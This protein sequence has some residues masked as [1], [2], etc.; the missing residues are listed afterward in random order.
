MNVNNEKCALI[1]GVSGQDGAYLAAFLIE[2]GYRVIG[3]TRNIHENNENLVKL[4]IVSKIRLLKVNLLNYDDVYNCI[5]N[6]LPDEIYHLSGQSSVGLSFEEPL[7][8]W[9]SSAISTTNILESVRKISAEIKIFNAASGECFDH[10]S[11]TPVTE[12]TQFSPNSPYSSAKI[13]S[14]VQIKLY[15]NYYNL[16]CSNGYLFNHES[17]LRSDKFVTIKII[18]TIQ[19]IKAGK[20]NIL[21]LGNIN[22]KRDWG[23]APEYVQAMWLMLQK[24]DPSDYI[25]ATGKSIKLKDFIEKTFDLYNLECDKY[26]TTTTKYKRKNEETKQCA[27]VTKINTDLKWSAKFDAYDVLEMLAEYNY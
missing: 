3:A 19:K 8:T 9:R 23:W 5:D 20:E 22:I 26:L 16:H 11:N 21:E 12:N 6:I 24:Q 4:N 2:N 7:I 17:P 15:R 25:I 27:N 10:S 14:A 18:K 13:A 1:T